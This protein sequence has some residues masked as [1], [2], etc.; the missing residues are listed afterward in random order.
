MNCQAILPAL[1]LALCVPLMAS[2]PVREVAEIRR[3][4]DARGERLDAKTL[5]LLKSGRAADLAQ[6][7]RQIQ[8]APPPESANIG[9]GVTG[10]KV[11]PSRKLQPGKLNSSRK[12]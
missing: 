10:K 5:D 12:R 3:L 9:Q 8:H 1:A 6:L 11:A 2:E 4:L 7:R